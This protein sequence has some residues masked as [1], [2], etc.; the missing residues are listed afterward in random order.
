[1]KRIEDFRSE[2]PQEMADMLVELAVRINHGKIIDDMTVL[3]AKV[4]KYKPEWATIRLPGMQTLK[5][6]KQTAQASVVVPENGEKL[7][8]M[9]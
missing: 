3:V 5:Q 7:I 8:P 1:K 4:A 9:S 6:R 2:D